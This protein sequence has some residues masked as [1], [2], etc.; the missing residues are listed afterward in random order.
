MARASD[1]TGRRAG[2]RILVVIL[3]RRDELHR[4]ASNV[5]ADG[6]A[7]EGWG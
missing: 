4:G 3:R 1:G 6:E 5:G 2:L 7:V